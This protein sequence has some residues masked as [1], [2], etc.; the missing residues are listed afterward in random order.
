MTERPGFSNSAETQDPAPSGPD[1]RESVFAS[2]P[3]LAALHRAYGYR[4]VFYPASASPGGALAVCEVKSRLT[5]RRWISVPFADHCEPGVADPAAL[6]EILRRFLADSA[7]RRSRYVELRPLSERWHEPLLA[8]GFA[9]SAQFWYHEIDLRPGVE[10]LWGNLHASSIR[11]KVRR[12]ERE[13][14][15]L[16][17]GNNEELLREY[18]RLHLRTRRRQ[19][20]PPQP[21]R[22][23]RILGEAFG[24]RL[25]VYL[26]L[27]EGQPVSGIV[28]LRWGTTLVYKYGASDERWNQLGGNPF[29]MWRAMEEGCS[30]GLETFDLGRTDL[31][32]PGLVQ[33]KERLGGVRRGLIYF[34]APASAA[35][36]TP[37]NV[38]AVWRRLPLPLLRLAGWLLYQHMA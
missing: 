36:S 14:L 28:T 15:E 33:Y 10:T 31:H 38:P 35:T 27:F 11:R 1:V 23:F 17:K 34:R 18:Y 32:N 37:A 3:W 2:E 7:V 9:P 21:F 25:R 12:A 6:N 5:G 20:V 8:L 29:L 4:P 26:A 22:W 16:R 19:G 30:A 13:G 24:E